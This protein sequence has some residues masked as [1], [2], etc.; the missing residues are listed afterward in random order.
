MA[1]KIFSTFSCICV[2]KNK[3]DAFHF[4]KN[5]ILLNTYSITRY[6]IVVVGFAIEIG[7][8]KFIVVVRLL[9]DIECPIEYVESNRSDFQYL[10]ILFKIKKTDA[11][12]TPVLIC[13]YKFMLTF[14][15]QF[16]HWLF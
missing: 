12:N 4:L 16:L 1:F 6:V 10:P 7:G 5:T 3:L 14:M 8:I 13:F 2:S 15:P 11:I 9:I